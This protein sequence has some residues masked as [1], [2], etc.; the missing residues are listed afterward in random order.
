[1]WSV[2]GHHDKV[3]VTAQPQE[4]DKA[5]KEVKVSDNQP[6]SC[7][8]A[9]SRLEKGQ[10][11]TVSVIAESNGVT[12]PASG[13]RTVTLVPSAPTLTSVH[14][15]SGSIKV[16]WSVE[17]HHDKVI[18]TAK[19]Q[20]GDTVREEVRVYDNQPQSCII[21]ASSMQKGQTY[22]V[23][24]I[25][26]SNGVT[27]P[28][29]GERTVTL[30]GNGMNGS[31][32]GVPSAPK[33]E[34]NG[35]TSPASGERTVTLGGNGM[36]GSTSGAPKSESNGV[37]SPASGERTVTLGGNG[38]NGSTSGE[39]GMV[40]LDKERLRV[41]RTFILSEVEFQDVRDLL[42]EK[43]ILS[44][45]DVQRCQCQTTP[46]DRMVC[47]LDML[48]KRG[49]KAFE[50]FCLSLKDS[51]PWVVEQLMSS[52]SKKVDMNTSSPQSQI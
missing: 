19:P 23:S 18:V 22:T 35:V 41:N 9:A 50:V 30:G 26:E 44:E 40:N 38:M 42:F 12:S 52:V 36:N 15:E 39:F 34:S 10:T 25:A 48:P 32:S 2:E 24:V 46:K 8:I 27:S 21:A 16:M 45:D 33:S 14:E 1:M 7:I 43:K 20:D 49:P 17:G 13:E 11:Y 37:T 5:R 31:T 47:L 4:G 28:A 3:I 29:S 6:Q 51:H